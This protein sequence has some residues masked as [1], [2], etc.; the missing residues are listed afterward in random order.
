[1][2]KLILEQACFTLIQ[3]WLAF[4]PVSAFNTDWRIAVFGRLMLN[5]VNRFS[6]QAKPDCIYACRTQFSKNLTPIF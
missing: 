5:F 6:E 1:M 4:S 2:K 3:K